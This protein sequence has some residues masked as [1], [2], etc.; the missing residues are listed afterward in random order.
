[1]KGAIAVPPSS[2]SK[3]N[4]SS[5]IS[6]GN[7][8]H[9]LLC[10]RKNQNSTGKDGCFWGAASLNLPDFFCRGFLAIYILHFR[11][12]GNSARAPGVDRG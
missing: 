6:I 5:M 1:M 4:R 11:T 3:H 9:F 7:S 12:V 10:L 2:T 8:H